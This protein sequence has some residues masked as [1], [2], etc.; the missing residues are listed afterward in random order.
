MGE[1]EERLIVDTKGDRVGVLPRMEDS[2]ELLD[3]A[4][5]KV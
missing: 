5:G 1:R 2:R 3:N 4:E